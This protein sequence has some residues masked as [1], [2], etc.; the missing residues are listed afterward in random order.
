MRARTTLGLALLLAACAGPGAGPDSSPPEPDD[1]GAAP[2]D[3]AEPPPDGGPELVAVSHDREVRGV[4]IATVF[5]I[6]WPSRAELPAA[7]QQR[8]LEALLDTAVAAG[9]NAVFFQIRA[10]ADAFY[11]SDLEPFSRFLTGTAG[12]DPGYDPLAHAVAQAHA[13]GLEL[14]AW[15]NPYRAW[16][17]ADASGAAATHLTRTRPELVVRYGDTHW[18]DP[19]L[20]AGRA[21][22]LAVIR[23]VLERYDVD[24]LHFD[25]YFYPYPGSG[26][27]FD[28]AAT[29]AAYRD[30]GGTLS[31]GDWRRDNVNRM[32]EA[33]HALVREVR[34]DV[35]FGI[36]PFGIYRPGMPEGIVGLD[37]YDAIYCDALAWLDGGWVDYLAPQLY[38]PTTR[39]GQ[40]FDR[41][42]SWWADRA[43]AAGRDLLAGS[44]L[45]QLGSS[46]EWT[47][48]ELLTQARLVRE[49]RDRR[50][51]GTI[52]YH[53]GPLAENREGA[54]DALA[55][56]LNATPAATPRLPG[57]EGRPAPPAVTV[58]G[59]E[60]RVTASEPIRHVA[61]YADGALQRLV[62]AARPAFVL[63]RGAYAI[64]VIDRRGRESLG[65]PIRIEADPPPPPP[66]GAPCTH[67]F[68]GVYA[69]RGC[70]PSYQCC[71]GSWVAR[72]D[73]GC[74]TCVCEEATGELGCSP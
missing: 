57:V 43:D 8:E 42:L 68:G 14:H 70:S 20:D 16:A 22:T 49:A 24:G 10:E 53:V 61:V 3:A 46:S 11:R 21:H 73:G 15:M 40:A 65:V 5:N 31:L 66:S 64:S 52:W 1:G 4:W 6:N 34:P 45:A 18:I 38:W 19:G 72:A 7:E 12:Q 36:S 48:E 74:G 23:D 62:P 44:Y 9:L 55:D 54:R 2:R 28:D 35:R 60:V 63:E 41:L 58:D 27:T 26:E 69:H 51:R 17:S 13:R 33:V 67:S 59:A 47:L 32:V 30:A 39:T 71:D 37:A 50:A 56:G 25:D 29:Y